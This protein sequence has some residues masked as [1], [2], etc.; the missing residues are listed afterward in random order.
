MA[1]I[2]VVEDHAMSR[3]MLSTLLGNMGYHVLEAADGVEALALAQSDHPDL[4]IS[5]ILMPTIDGMEFVRQL[6]TGAATVETPVIF[7]TATF[8]LPEA[9]RSDEMFKT[10]R[11]IPKPSDPAIILQTINEMLKN[12]PASPAPQT[13]TDLPRILRGKPAFSQHAGLQL[14]L[15][16]ELSYSMVAQRNPKQLLSTISRAL[17]EILGCPKSLLAIRDDDG[18]MCY[19]PGST[20]NEPIHSCPSDLLPPATI[21][22]R[23]LKERVPL[24]WRQTPG[25]ALDN[26]AHFHS[27]FASLLIIP[28]AS[29]GRVYGWI[30]LKDKLEGAPFTAGDEEI[31]M[32]LSTQAA[33]AYENILLVEQLRKNEEYLEGLV[34]E[35]TAELERVHEELWRAQKLESLGVLAGGIAHDFNNALTAIINHIQIAKIKSKPGDEANRYLNSAEKVCHIASALTKQLLTFAKGGS[36][37]K[38]VAMLTDLIRDTVEFALRGSKVK[39]EFFIDPDLSMVEIDQGQISQVISNLVINAEQAMPGGGIVRVSA[40][41]V[42]VNSKG[43]LPL[44]EGRYVR[45]SV[46]DQGVGIARED[47]G[48]IFDPYY[49]TKEMGSGLGLATSYSIVKKHEGL[50]TV[51]SEEDA[52]TAFHVYLP[53]SDKKPA[54]EEKSQ[55]MPVSG[56]RI[57]LIEDEESLA[58]TLT[59]L[60]EFYGYSADCAWDGAEGLKLY[61]SAMKKGMKYN[62]VIMDLTIPGGM[63]GKEA[64]KLLREMDSDVIAIVASGYSNDPV[65]SN[66]REYGFSEAISKPY[67]IEDMIDKLHR[68][69]SPTTELVQ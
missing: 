9:L 12:T 56:G 65:M 39:C 38:E 27:S 31:A 33:L 5:D 35:R 59:E 8:R 52:G 62:A 30:S 17:C 64:I 45:L 4:I 68:I 67:R 6:R 16:M 37:V 11:V 19:Y 14:A 36:P 3:Q 53:A 49:T 44:K 23:V 54:E 63:G 50:I 18:K 29:P 24:R 46:I 40:E 15:L 57:L 61:E 21:L 69:L 43:R 58:E 22:E 47:L 10:C 20:E 26:K 66:Y 28:F 2:L 1:T 34:A 13:V 32:T 48:R 7:Y 25:T 60:L 51:E 42:I 41:N 55:I